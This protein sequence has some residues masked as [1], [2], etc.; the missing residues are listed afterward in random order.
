MYKINHY[1]LVKINPYRA[2]YLVE[3][4]QIEPFRNFWT[5]LKIIIISTFYPVLIASFH[6]VWLKAV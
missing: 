6:D 1:C 4:K 3:V 5:P 2:I